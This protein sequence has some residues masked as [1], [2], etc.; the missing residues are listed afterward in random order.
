MMLAISATKA[1]EAATSSQLKI[2]EAGTTPLGFS[3]GVPE[4]KS[5]INL[6][7]NFK[8]STRSLVERV[9]T[10]KNSKLNLE[11]FLTSPVAKEPPIQRATNLSLPKARS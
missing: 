6:A 1:K 5:N 3:P 4:K 9:P 11:T 8:E 2:Y 10:Y 7:T